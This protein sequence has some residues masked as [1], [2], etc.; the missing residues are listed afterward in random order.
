MNPEVLFIDQNIPYLADA[1]ANCGRVVR[2]DGRTLTNNQLAH[3]HCTSLFV[4]SVTKVNPSL[5]QN[6]PVR[7][8]GT[9][10][11][12][13]DHIDIDYLNTSGIHFAPAPGS[14]ANAVAEYVLFAILEWAKRM[15]CPLK[16]KS[17]GIIGYG[18]VGKLV[19]K[20]CNRLGMKILV[21]DPPLYDNGFQFP[22]WTSYLSI[23]D[24]CAQSDIVTNHVPLEINGNY[25][26]QGILGSREL[27][28]VKPGALIVHAS[29]GGVIDEKALIEASERKQLVLAIDVWSK[30]PFIDFQLATKTI[31]ATPHI[32][33]Y[34]WNAKCNG[35]L[36]MA[37]QFEEFSG[38]SPDYAC[39]NYIHSDFLSD[40]CVDETT[41]YQSLAE[42]RQ[43]LN[44]TNEFQQL[45]S[46]PILKRAAEFDRLRKQYPQRFES[47]R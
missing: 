37:K 23:E 27:D 31:I 25:P 19:A 39:I 4:R 43:F 33:G 30:E 8:V 47:M 20:Y 35:A 24:L 46:L 40:E 42:R 10:T 1:L 12:G 17:V 32:A 34:S 36:M 21:N 18:N 14:N 7:F 6:T 11:A 29:R 22:E 45:H 38:C 44:D 28:E 9:A 15:D 2:F 13:T 26:T 16:G 5:V 41:L 3:E